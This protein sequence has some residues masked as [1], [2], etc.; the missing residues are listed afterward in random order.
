[1][2]R[3]ALLLFRAGLKCRGSGFLSLGT[4]SNLFPCK[5]IAVC[6]F[7]SKPCPGKLNYIG[8]LYKRQLLHR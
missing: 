2:F 8:E 7:C 5:N 6:L 1:M 4:A 3:I